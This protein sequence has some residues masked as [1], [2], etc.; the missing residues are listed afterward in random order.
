MNSK[1]QFNTKP[2]TTEGKKRSLTDMVFIFVIS[3]M[4]GWVVEVGYVFLV[5]GKFV[6]RGMIYGPFCTIYGFGALIL[7]FLFYN[8]KPTKANIP[9]TFI[10]AAFVMGAFEL[11][12]GLGFKYIFGIE[13]WNY[14]G[15]FL[16]ILNYTTVPI[17]IGWGVLGTIYV[18]FLQPLLLK[19]ISW[20]PKGIEKRLAIIIVVF[21]VLNVGLSF[22]NIHFNPEILYKLVD[23][24]L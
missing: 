23:P 2:E 3:A 12:C 19:V 5:V 10:T 14:H 24:T 13:M 11:V 21:Y 6:S 15:Q 18:F 7:Y 20:L 8:V 17:L 1:F 9:Y 22:F 4:L 16:E